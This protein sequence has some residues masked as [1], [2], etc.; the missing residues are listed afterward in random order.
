[1]TGS[2]RSKAAASPP[3]MMVSTPRSAP[4][5]PPEIGASRKWTPFL[6]AAASISRAAAADTVLW[7]AKMAPSA[8]PASTPASSRVTER[9]SSSLPTQVKTKAAPSAA[10]RGVGAVAP[11]NSSAHCLAL[12][13]V[14][15]KTVTSWPALTR[16]PAM[17]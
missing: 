13:A 7:S 5:W 16:C 9:R 15:L 11:P 12:A 8:I 2:A 6:P 3:T 10:A 14:R 1:M 17:G 4:A